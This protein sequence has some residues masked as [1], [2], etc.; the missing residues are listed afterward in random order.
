MRVGAASSTPA[1][2]GSAA[3]TWASSRF[4]NIVRLGRCRGAHTANLHGWTPHP[5]RW[6]RW[7]RHGDAEPARRLLLRRK[8]SYADAGA[9]FQL[10]LQLLVR[11]QQGDV[12]NASGV[13]TIVMDW[14][15]VR[16]GQL[17]RH[18]KLRG[19][20]SERECRYIPEHGCLPRRPTTAT[21]QRFTLIQPLQLKALLC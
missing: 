2:A 17:H 19:C 8:D 18:A 12:L 9:R 1:P 13:Y 5:D 4:T 10:L 14:G 3:M 20:F 15:Q 16:L 6:R 7:Q 21:R 11:R